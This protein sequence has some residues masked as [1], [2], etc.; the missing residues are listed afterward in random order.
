[1]I[2][3]D[4]MKRLKVV[5]L[6]FDNT[7]CLHTNRNTEIDQD[8]IAGTY[9]FETSMPNRHLRE[10]VELCRMQGIQLGVISATSLAP[11]V[12]VKMEW[13]REHYG[14]GF[15]NWCVGTAQEKASLLDIISRVQHLNPCSIM[16]VDDSFD[17][18]H[19]CEKLGFETCT[20]ME[21]VNYM[22]EID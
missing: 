9:K 15:E 13:V 1:M 20:P 8:I 22:E 2:N 3:N 6:D 17:A 21:I 5:A 16:I 18:L 7:L 12:Q 4:I 14:D 19:M 10:F 11:V